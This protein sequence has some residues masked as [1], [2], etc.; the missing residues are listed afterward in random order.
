MTAN[1]KVL[2][3]G[4]GAGNP[5]YLT[6][7]A[8]NALNRVSVF[9]IPNKGIEKQA[10]VRIRHEICERFI[11]SKTYRFVEFDAPTR[12]RS[13][14]NYRSAVDDWHAKV[15]RAYENLL[16]A[17]LGENE[18][19]AFLVW[20]DPALYDSTLR[21]LDRL[22]S[23]RGFEFDYEVIPG[24]TS[25]QALAAKHKVALNNIGESVTITTGRKLAEGFPN[26]ADS[27]VVMLTRGDELANIKSD[28]DIYWGANIGTD[29]EVLVSGKLKDVLQEIERLRLATHDKAGW[30]MDTYLL[31]KPDK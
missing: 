23:K 8:I 19:G 27:V 12:D 20:G 29:D 6:I 31:K 10:L 13:G 3:I 28:A 15:E 22:R 16:I 1:R 25:I 17:E 21:I 18:C 2:I 14:K 5:E 24:I 30:V 26:N 4:I 7:Q 11:R 9:F